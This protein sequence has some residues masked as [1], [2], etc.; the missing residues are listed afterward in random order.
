MAKKR[1]DV[2]V[3]APF[4][5]TSDYYAVA[6]DETGREVANAYGKDRREATAKVVQKVRSIYGSDAEVLYRK[7]SNMAEQL[8]NLRSLAACIDRVE[9][10][11]AAGQLLEEAEAL[12][13]AIVLAPEVRGARLRLALIYMELEDGLHL[14]QV[15][16]AWQKEDPG[17]YPEQFASKQ[18]VIASALTV[19]GLDIKIKTGDNERAL[20][21]LHAGGAAGPR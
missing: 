10:F 18:G 21:V 3:T 13:E 5:G 4:L 11:R 17:T 7:E 6:R 2:S 14:A 15:L 19:Q 1:I 20:K 9:Q 8:E 16:I 12:R